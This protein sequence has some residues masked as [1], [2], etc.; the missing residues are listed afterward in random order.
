VS[1]GYMDNGV[2]EFTYNT[3]LFRL[4]KEGIIGT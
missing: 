1:S 4:K 3:I 2:V